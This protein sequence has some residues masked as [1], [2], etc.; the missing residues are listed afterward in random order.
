MTYDPTTQPINQ[1]RRKDRT[2]QDD[3]WIVEFLARTPWGVLATSY[4]GQPFTNANLFVYE[5]VSHS[6]FMHT[7]REGRTRFNIEANPRVCLSVS[8]MG[9]LL[10]ADTAM[11]FS[12]E[13]QSVVIFGQAS[14]IA[15]DGEAA[16][17]MQL[18]LDKYIPHLRPV[19]D[20]RPIQA[21]E[22]ALT[23]VFRVDIES[24]SAK[25]K[26][27]AEDFPG[28]FMFGEKTMGG[29]MKK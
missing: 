15:E 28:A 19:S 7:A 22:L 26:A 20:Y 10:P 1:L 18:L 9:R 2:I 11:E 17:G 14:V 23:A 4:E 6:L 27:A 12:V 13:Y 3:T 25:R 24:W 29:V 5:Q 21:K 8:E 16:R